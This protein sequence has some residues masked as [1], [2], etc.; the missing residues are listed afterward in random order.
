MSI[1]DC[2]TMK[3]KLASVVAAT[4]TAQTLIKYKNTK[5]FLHSSGT[6]IYNPF[7]ILIYLTGKARHAKCAKW[8]ICMDPVLLLAYYLTHR[9]HRLSAKYYW[10]G[11]QSM[12]Y[13]NWKWG[14]R[15]FRSTNSFLVLFLLFLFNFSQQFL[16]C[17]LAVRPDKKGNSRNHSNPNKCS[18]LI[19]GND[20]D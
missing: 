7:K 12:I 18:V 19:K 15:I 20:N 8:K 6:D 13:Q 5:L 3:P 9:H 10:I 16:Y 14:E 11:A 4:A 17:F 2:G 1:F